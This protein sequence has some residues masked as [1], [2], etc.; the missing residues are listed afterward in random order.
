MIP[1]MLKHKRSRFGMGA[2]LV[3]LT[4]FHYNNQVLIKSFC[5][6]NSLFTA[7]WPS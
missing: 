5:Y 4:I 7:C 6:G 3:L 1:H 2:A